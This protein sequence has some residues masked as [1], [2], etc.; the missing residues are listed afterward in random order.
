MSLPANVLNGVNGVSGGT[1][2]R[3]F[4]GILQGLM[5]SLENIDSDSFEDEG[6]RAQAVVAAYALI[7]RLETP[8]EFLARIGMG[9]PAL[10]AS[11]K[12]GKDLGLYG[13]WHEAG[14]EEKT[15]QELA[16]LV[17]C[18]TILLDRILRHLAANHMVD[19]P[20][21]G[22]FRPNKFTTSFLQPSFGEWINHLYDATIPCFFRMPEYLAQTGYKN[23]ADPK[24][25]VFQ[26]TKGCK[27]EDCFHYFEKN[28][29]EGTSFDH[30][31]SGVM[32][33]QAGWLD[34]Y[35]HETVVSQAKDDS[36]PLVVD[37]GG[38]IG[39]D[40]ERFRAAHPE[41]ASRLFLMDRPEVV[42][43]SRLPDPVNK[44]GYDFFTPQQATGARIYYMHGV[45]HDWPDKEARK[46]LEMQRDALTPGYSKVLIHDHIA[47]K[48]LAHPHTTAYDLTMMVMVAG[49]ERSEDSWNALLNSAGYKLVKIWRSPE[50][51]QGIIEAELAS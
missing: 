30:V 15:S 17:G 11:L 33:N 40:L 44:I 23:P 7:A 10:G 49:E 8:W 48:A 31:M 13:K 3:G 51:V 20:S 16:S 45:L 12:V 27:G 43:R 14:G 29:R 6:E 4:Q 34:I 38:S 25:G 37:V 26:Y 42:A 32:A 36:S 35:P 28:P 46:I 1:R 24:D 50:A 41:T 22:R 39:H 9:Q 18:D 2:N 19:E 47:P 5:K 21:I